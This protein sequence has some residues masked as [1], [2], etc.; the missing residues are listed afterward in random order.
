MAKA[1]DASTLGVH[2]PNSTLIELDRRAAL[3]DYSRSKYAGAIIQRWFS[4]KRAEP[5]FAIEKEKL[6]PIPLPQGGFTWV[7]A[8]LKPGESMTAFAEDSDDYDLRE[9]REFKA[10]EDAA[11]PPASPQKKPVSALGGKPRSVASLPLS[12]SQKNTG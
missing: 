3:L 6:D 12:G 9:P 7:G 10:A 1:K 5:I 8:G 11:P 2:L 4:K